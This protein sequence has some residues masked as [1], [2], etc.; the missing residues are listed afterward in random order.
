MTTIPI[1]SDATA[2]LVTVIVTVVLHLKMFCN[3][4]MTGHYRFAAGGRPPEDQKLKPGIPKQDFHGAAAS[5]SAQDDSVKA[6][7]ASLDRHLRI[8]ANDN[9]NVLPGLFVVWASAL[10]IGTRDWA[11]TFHIVCAAVFGFSRVAHS[12]CYAYSKQPWRTVFWALAFV[13]AVAMGV[14]AIIG[15]VE[16]TKL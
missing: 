13:A 6:A 11:A 15:A 7:K 16:Y 8:L 4:L 3:A 12:L 14:N 9:E 2:I 1:A 5:S 10:T